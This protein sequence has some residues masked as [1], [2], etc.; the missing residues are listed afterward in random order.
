MKPI[1]GN[2]VG[3]GAYS[4]YLGSMPPLG[5]PYQMPVPQKALDMRQS[6]VDYLWGSRT[7]ISPLGLTY[8][9]PWPKR[10]LP[11]FPSFPI[12]GAESLTENPDFPEGSTTDRQELGLRQTSSSA[13][14]P[15]NRPTPPPSPPPASPQQQPDQKPWAQD[16]SLRETPK[17]GPSWEEGTAVLPDSSKASDDEAVDVE[18]NEEGVQRIT[19]TTQTQVS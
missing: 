2:E 12:S 6:F 15:V 19:Q 17:V 18:S 1:P 9:L 3:I 11:S 13:F 7:G 4:S 14:T 10:P 16:E 8:P 5:Q